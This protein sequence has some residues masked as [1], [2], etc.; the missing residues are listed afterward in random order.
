VVQPWH[1]RSA[2]A[3]V[4]LNRNNSAPTRCNVERLVDE[5]L[6][7]GYSRAFTAALRPQEAQPFLNA[8]FRALEDLAVLR[9][10]LCLPLATPTAT[11]R[12]ARRKDHLGV[13]TLDNRAFGDFWRLDSVSL[14]EALQA[15][16]TARFRVSTQGDAIV[17]YAVCGQSAGIGYL[18]RL[19]VAPESFGHGIGSALVMDAL[20][21]CKRRG[22]SHALVNTQLTNL[23][24]LRLYRHLGFLEAKERL[25]VLEWT[26]E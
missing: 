1:G 3:S 12:R 9:H 24:A 10:G 6:S 11:H 25:H 19:G 8:G 13:L 20:K 7:V 26:P 22:A 4:G 21:W 16:T 17:G 2:I 14:K 18:Q 23:R 15:T 5:L